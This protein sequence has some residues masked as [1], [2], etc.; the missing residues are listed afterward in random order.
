MIKGFRSIHWITLVFALLSFDSG[1]KA[2]RYIYG[3]GGT[4]AKWTAIGLGLFLL[5]EVYEDVMK[6]RKLIE[7]SEQNQQII[8]E[9]VQ[10]QEEITEHEVIIEDE[11]SKVDHEVVIE[12]DN[13]VVIEEE[14]EK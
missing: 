7:E 9:E 6:N 8:N 4:S 1:A 2:L 5:Y 10:P 11:E 13:E 14:K 3:V 12:D